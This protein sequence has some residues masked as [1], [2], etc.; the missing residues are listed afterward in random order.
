MSEYSIDWNVNTGSHW[1][2]VTRLNIQPLSSLSFIVS[3]RSKSVFLKLLIKLAELSSRS[4]D[5]GKWKTR[6][7]DV[8]I[9]SSIFNK[10]HLL[11]YITWTDTH[12]IIP[13]TA[14]TS[15]VNVMEILYKYLTRGWNVANDRY[16]H[17]STIVLILF[18]LT[19]NLK[20]ASFQSVELKPLSIMTLWQATVNVHA[21]LFLK[22]NQ[23]GY[24]KVMSDIW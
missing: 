23:A 12:T 24:W 16:L 20:T 14:A 4:G 7:W 5:L 10:G 18:F 15:V 1:A 8:D 21:H 19:M 11:F 17:Q 22:K 6:K 9:D 2:P 13:L 3:Q